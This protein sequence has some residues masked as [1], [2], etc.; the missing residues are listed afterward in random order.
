MS[1]IHP[2][3]QVPGRP[4]PKKCLLDGYCGVEKI[5]IRV[6]KGVGSV[7]ALLGDP[8]GVTPSL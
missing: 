4:P 8:R 5:L 1:S 7:T 3:C 2:V 6:G